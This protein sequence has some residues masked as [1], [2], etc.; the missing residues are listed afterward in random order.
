MTPVE[1]A[2]RAVRVPFV[3]RGRSYDGW[4]CWGLVYVGYRDVLGVGLPDY[5]DEYDARLA[6]GEL[7]LLILEHRREAWRRVDPPG[8]MDV[9]LYRVGRYPSHV[10]LVVPGRRLLHTEAGPGTVLE[11]LA[12]RLWG[13]RVEG[14]YRH[15]V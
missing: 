15:V 3:P 5:L 4:D 10:G 7:A 12:A 14:Y 1:F 13:D 6:Y 11:P 9:A 2:R 8:P